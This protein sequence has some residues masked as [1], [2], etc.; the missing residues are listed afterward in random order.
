MQTDPLGFD[1]SGTFGRPYILRESSLSRLSESMA[2]C[3]VFS[4]F[5]GNQLSM[6]LEGS[7]AYVF[8]RSPFWGIFKECNNVQIQCL[9]KLM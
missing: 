3:A 5:R 1:I 4:T 6:A 2:G 8:H 7:F 9:E